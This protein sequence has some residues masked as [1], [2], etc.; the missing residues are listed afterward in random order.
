MVDC[1]NINL[2]KNSTGEKVTQ[3]QTILKQKGYYTGKLDGSYGSYTVEAVKKFQKDKGLLQDGI[4]GP[5]TCKK[6]QEANTTVN[7]GKSYYKN[8]VY[9]SSP[10][11]ISRGC[12]KLGQCN[13]YYCAPHS[14]RQC[15]SKQDID[16]YKEATIA[17]WAGTTSAGT[18]H[19]GIETAIATLAKKTGKKIKVQWK[20]FSDL[21]SNRNA[22]FKAI[23]ELICKQNIGVIFHLLYKNKWGHYE[24]IREVN[25]NNN[26]VTVLNSLGSKCSAPAYC[27]SLEVRSFATMES[28][29]R[30]ISQKSICIVTYE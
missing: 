24:T 20:N 1:N 4:V 3:I 12:N 21:G 22:R 23:G 28:Y 19:Y 18:S 30:G 16:E 10:H 15:N 7:E 6:L 29:L 25:M 17:G 8:G 9:H 5:V 13:G 2:M 26:T 11:W 27:G 14:I